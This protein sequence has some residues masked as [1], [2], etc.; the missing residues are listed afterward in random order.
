MSNLV[1]WVQMMTI[2]CLQYPMEN[3]KMCLSPH[4]WLPEYYYDYVRFTTEAPYSR[5]KDAVRESLESRSSHE[6]Q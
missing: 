4:Q 2:A 5:E 6:W 3:M 1:L